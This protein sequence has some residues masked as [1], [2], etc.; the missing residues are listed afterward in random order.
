MNKKKESEGHAML[1]LTDQ[2]KIDLD[3]I[4][5]RVLGV[6]SRG[7][8]AIVRYWINQYKSDEPVS[9]CDVV[10]N[11]P[12]GKT[13]KV[14]AKIRSVEKWDPNVVVLKSDSLKDWTEDFLLENGIYTCKCVKCKSSF[15]GHKRRYICR[16]CCALPY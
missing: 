13:I 1:S 4:A 10:S 9:N 5:L 14:K 6:N 15:T 12:L 7:R 16:E 11:V 2:E 3:K 8:S